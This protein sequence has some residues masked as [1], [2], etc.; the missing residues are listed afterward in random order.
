MSRFLF[1]TIHPHCVLDNTNHSRFRWTQQFIYSLLPQR[2]VSAII[3]LVRMEDGINKPSWQ[4]WKTE[5]TVTVYSVFHSWQT[6][7]GPMRQH[8]VVEVMNKWTTLFDW[9]YC[10]SWCKVY[11]LWK[12]GQVR[13]KQ[14][15]HIQKVR[16][17]RC[18]CMP[19]H[20]CVYRIITWKLLSVTTCC[21]SKH[22]GSFLSELY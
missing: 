7:V 14:I 3:R 22:V 16:H 6:D 19:A 20:V 17:P 1:K 9:N 11:D 12:Q 10:D 8:Q 15:A 21:K 18:V 5:Y 4:E 13:R 2:Q